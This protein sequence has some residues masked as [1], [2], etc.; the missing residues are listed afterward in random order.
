M[1]GGGSVG[2]RV[3]RVSRAQHGGSKLNYG[4]GWNPRSALLGDL[5]LMRDLFLCQGESLAG[6]PIKKDGDLC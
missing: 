1:M 2:F 5:F 3:L 4:A 6:D